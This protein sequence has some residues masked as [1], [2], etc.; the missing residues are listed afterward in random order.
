MQ[1]AEIRPTEEKELPKPQANTTKDNVTRAEPPGTKAQTAE[2]TS[3]KLEEIRQ[4]IKNS[5]IPD[6]P[7]GELIE[8]KTNKAIRQIGQMF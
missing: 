4:E 7:V 5:Q 1:D 2:E 6:A 3:V 8:K